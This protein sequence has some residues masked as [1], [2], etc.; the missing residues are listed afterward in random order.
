MPEA[1]AALPPKLEFLDN[2]QPGLKSGVYELSVSQAVSIRGTPADATGADATGADAT[3]ADATG[4]DATGADATGADA[5]GADATGARRQHIGVFGERFALA[6]DDVVSVFPPPGSLG[7]HADVLPHVVLRRSTLPWERRVGIAGQPAQ[8]TIPWMAVLVFG[9]DDLAAG[10]AQPPNVRLG[11]LQAPAE[12][13]PGLELEPAQH[14]DDLVTVIDVP[15]SLLSGMLPTGAELRYLAH[16]RRGLNEAGELQ[17]EEHAVVVAGRLPRGGGA[18]VAHLVSLEGRY[19][20]DFH[21]LSYHF[22]PGESGRVRLV[23]LKSWRFSCLDAKQNFAALL[24]NLDRAP[25]ELRLP[26]AGGPAEPYLARGYVPCP[27]SLR[28]GATSVSW[29]HGPLVPRGSAEP[30]PGGLY[31]VRAADALLRY[32]LDTGL[33]DTGYSAAW[34]LGRLLALGS[35]RVATTLSRW[36]HELVRYAHA[37]THLAE[38][39]LPTTPRAVE[40]PQLPAVALEWLAST[41]LL[42]GIPFNYLVP[43]ERMLP[44]DSMRM[45]TVDPAWMASLFDGALSVGRVTSAHHAADAVRLPEVEALAART[46]HGVLVRSSVVA[47]WPSLVVEGFMRTPAAANI[48]AVS[49]KRIRLRIERL[50]RDVLLC[51]F[52][53]EVNTIEM[54]QPAEAVHFAVTLGQSQSLTRELRRADGRT[55]DLRVTVPVRARI[56][57]VIDV[58]SLVDLLMEQQGALGL[59]GPFN[60]AKFAL[61]MLEIVPMVCFGHPAPAPAPRPRIILDDD[62]LGPSDPRVATS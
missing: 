58:A 20:F 50:S 8:E 40:R 3:G 56:P 24:A 60:S 14:G 26:P 38:P 42:C 53:R 49:D 35:G 6:E 18:S 54:H 57:R 11:T 36:R 13:W 52:D 30:V 28:R 62:D 22:P 59:T 27:H 29:Y 48:P 37:D 2:H 34:E 44:A 43:D 7:D 61:Q 1:T 9:E 45:F 39:H 12:G 16:V 25:A 4:A 17:G 47:G 5:T 33:L 10:V 15:H 55:A 51:L 32:D 46:V 23:S 21:T 31:P 19:E 41:A